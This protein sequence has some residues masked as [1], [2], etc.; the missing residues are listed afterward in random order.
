MLLMQ[1]EVYCL[2]TSKCE[3]VIRDGHKYV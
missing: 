2:C 1:S 3:P